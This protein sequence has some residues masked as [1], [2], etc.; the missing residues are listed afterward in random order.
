MITLI[1]GLTWLLDIN[2]CEHNNGGCEEG[3]INTVGSYSCTCGP[4]QKLENNGRNCSG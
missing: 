2:E 1:F 3:C 4:S